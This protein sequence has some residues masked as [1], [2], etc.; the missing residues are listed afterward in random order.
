MWKEQV[1]NRSS[2]L[3][4][5]MKKRKMALVKVVFFFDEVH[6]YE[7]DTII[8]IKRS[9]LGKVAHPRTFYI[10]TDGYVREGF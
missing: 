4:H 6:A 10:G 7:K 2:C 3:I 1:P 5:L 8:N 9:G